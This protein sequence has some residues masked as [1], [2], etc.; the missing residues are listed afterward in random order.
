MPHCIMISIIRC[1]I[2]CFDGHICRE[3][4]RERQTERER[5]RERDTSAE[6]ALF[7][8]HALHV[9]DMYVMPR[10]IYM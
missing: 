10:C 5:E 6:H 9:H 4:E 8:H 7:H 3:R 1:D 2:I